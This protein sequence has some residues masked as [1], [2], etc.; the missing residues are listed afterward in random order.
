MTVIVKIPTVDDLYLHSQAEVETLKEKI[1]VLQNA[2]VTK[3]R[4]Y[5]TAMLNHAG[6]SESWSNI[7]YA[8]KKLYF[9]TVKELE[10]AT[11]NQQW[12]ADQWELESE[13][14]DKLKKKIRR[15]KK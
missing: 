2:I 11:G 5:E 14:N 3:D 15:L 1:Q 10:L 9:D 7:V 4:M 12:W 8:W 13:K 6:E